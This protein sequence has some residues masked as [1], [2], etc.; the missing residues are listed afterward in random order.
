MFCDNSN[1]KFTPKTPT[2]VIFIPKKPAD[3]KTFELFDITKLG[4]QYQGLVSDDNYACTKKIYFKDKDGNAIETTHVDNST[5]P[6]V[7][8]GTARSKLIVNLTQSFRDFL[9]DG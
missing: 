4:F 9:V 1:V 2:P 5:E 7:A 3:G 6:A 8:G